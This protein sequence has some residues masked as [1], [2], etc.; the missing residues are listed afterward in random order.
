MNAVYK[1]VDGRDQVLLRK[2]RLKPYQTLLLES[3]LVDEL[4]GGCNKKV[5]DVENGSVGDVVG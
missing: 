1:L 5:A 3:K 2:L 4:V